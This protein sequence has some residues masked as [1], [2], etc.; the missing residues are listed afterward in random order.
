MLRLALA[1]LC[2]SLMGYTAQGISLF[3]RHWIEH[4][5]SDPDM[6]EETAKQARSAGC[7]LCHVKGKEKKTSRNEYGEALSK[8]LDAS[9]FPDDW[10][11]ANPE[12][13]KRKIIT[14]FQ[15]VEEELRD[16]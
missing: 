6:D 10:V 1:F 8:F 14:A 3:N 13:A 2:L 4:Y 7:Y 11:E 12:E 16:D 5:L 15:K 9:D